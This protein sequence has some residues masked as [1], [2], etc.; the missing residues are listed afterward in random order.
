[1]FGIKRSRVQRELPPIT[2]ENE[3]ELGC[4]LLDAFRGST[5]SQQVCFHC[6]ARGG[7]EMSHH[8]N[9]VV[10][11]A[12]DRLF[13]LGVWDHTGRRYLTFT[14][15]SGE[16]KTLRARLQQLCSHTGREHRPTSWWC[17]E[18]Y[19]TGPTSISQP[20]A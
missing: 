17:P 10:G 2:A 19:A 6:G 14:E 16:L 13:T 7:F 5:G 11:A 18:C 9:C 8:K 12:A 3:H 15:H 20:A 4:A 1:M